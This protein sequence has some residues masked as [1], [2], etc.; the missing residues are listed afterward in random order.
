MAMVLACIIYYGIIPNRNTPTA[1]VLGWGVIIPV[2]AYIPYLQVEY[3]DSYNRFVNL[4][5]TFLMG[6]IG[7]RCM[8][9]MYIPTTPNYIEHSLTNY[10]VHCSTLG[11]YQ[12]DDKTQAIAKA[13]I[14]DTLGLLLEILFFF[15]VSSILVSWMIVTEFKPFESTVR[16]NQFDLWDGQIFHPHHLLNS[17]L[18][19]WVLFSTFKI[20]FEAVG[21]VE[22]LKGYATNRVFYNPL[23]QS[24][25]VTEFWNVRWN[26]LIHN[27]LKYGTYM[28]ASSHHQ[29]GMYVTKASHEKT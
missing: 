8:S 14:R 26:R 12:W 7:V 17:Y 28:I 5:A 10:I 13:N 24:S 22:N 19:I 18:H 9:A 3:F 21:L 1:Y 27:L 6:C 29:D 16:L 23:T 11:L 25:S 20:G 15:M 2:S 4:P